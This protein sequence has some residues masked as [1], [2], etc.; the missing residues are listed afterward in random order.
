MLRIFFVNVNTS[1]IF[2]VD[3]QKPV[4]PRKINMISNNER[5]DEIKK[6]IV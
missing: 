6:Y 2:S 1:T 5:N 4:F 3:P